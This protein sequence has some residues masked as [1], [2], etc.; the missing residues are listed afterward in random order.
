MR[1]HDRELAAA[2][3]QPRIGPDQAFC[4]EDSVE[5]MES[6]MQAVLHVPKM[7]VSEAYYKRKLAVRNYCFYS[8][9]DDAFSMH[10]WDE[11]E[12]KRGGNEIISAAL[13]HLTTRATGA[14]HLIW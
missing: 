12:A 4:A 6:D 2:V 8:A 13:K 7:P 3:S 9:Q 11:R 10:F 14:S 1:A 5:M